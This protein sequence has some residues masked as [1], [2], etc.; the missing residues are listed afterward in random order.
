VDDS[1]QG[2]ACN[3]PQ[4]PKDDEDAGEGHQHDGIFNPQNASTGI[5]CGLSECDSVWFHPIS[6]SHGTAPLQWGETLP[7]GFLRTGGKRGVVKT[8]ILL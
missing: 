4:C 3:E 2:D 6:L 7:C 1:A 5:G 8:L